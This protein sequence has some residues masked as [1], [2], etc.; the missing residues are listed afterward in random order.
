MLACLGGSL[1]SCCG[2]EVAGDS[3]AEPQL[4]E[5]ECEEDIELVR[6]LGTC[7][8]PA[9]SLRFTICTDRVSFSWGTLWER[10]DGYL[11]TIDECGQSNGQSWLGVLAALLP[12]PLLLLTVT[13]GSCKGRCDGYSQAA[14]AALTRGGGWGPRRHPA[15]ILPQLAAAAAAAA[16]R[17]D[18]A[19][20]RG[21]PE[22]VSSLLV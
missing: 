6:C 21:P 16:R 8:A 10:G 2:G 13:A 18:E 3:E 19:E 14:G 12:P 9:A 1:A 17:A 4:L 15:Q 22:V 7:T 5:P 20:A 11:E